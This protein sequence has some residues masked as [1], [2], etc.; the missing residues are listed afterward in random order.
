[1]TSGSLLWV[2]MP[3][4]LNFP[5]FFAFAIA[6]STGSAKAR[7]PPGASL[8]DP[9]DHLF[10]SALHV[11]MGRVQKQDAGIEGRPDEVGIVRVHHPHVD[12]RELQPGFPQGPVHLFPLLS[13][14]VNALFLRLVFERGEE[15]ESAEPRQRRFEEM[16]SA[17][18][19]VLHRPLRFLISSL[20]VSHQTASGISTADRHPPNQKCPRYTPL[21]S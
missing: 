13:L 11:G 2:V 9:S 15:K 12:H 18:C 5:S 21:S 6:L 3:A 19:L 8:D 20:A 14:D 7:S 1:M 10:V 16:P 4:N 17:D